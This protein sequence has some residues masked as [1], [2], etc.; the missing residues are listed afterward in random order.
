M[1]VRNM[2]PS[3]NSGR[4][5]EYIWVYLYVFRIPEPNSSANET[6]RK[7]FEIGGFFEYGSSFAKLNSPQRCGRFAFSVYMRSRSITNFAIAPEE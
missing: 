2:S 7:T 5:P 3:I 4:L 6:S 1:I